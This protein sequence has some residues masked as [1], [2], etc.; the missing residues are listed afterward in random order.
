MRPGSEKV[1]VLEVSRSPWSLDPIDNENTFDRAVPMTGSLPDCTYL[2]RATPP[3]CKLANA[4]GGRIRGR[5]GENRCDLDHIAVS[6]SNK[7][8]NGTCREDDAQPRVRR[9]KVSAFIWQTS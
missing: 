9:F 5:L 3:A 4:F 7:Q 2:E 1:A 6:L 8:N